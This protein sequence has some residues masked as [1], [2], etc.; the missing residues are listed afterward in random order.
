MNKEERVE[1]ARKILHDVAEL[2]GCVMNY[3]CKYSLTREVK[4]TWANEIGEG[5]S[6]D[7]ERE[8]VTWDQAMFKIE[9]IACGQEDL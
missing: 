8:L 2:L 7:G 1:K 3:G 5:F 4:E 9:E 6:E